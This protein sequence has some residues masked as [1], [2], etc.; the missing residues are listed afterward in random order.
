MQIDGS[1]LGDFSAR[2]V[3][4]AISN[5]YVTVSEN[6]LLLREL[7][8]RVRALEAAGGVRSGIVVTNAAIT[9]MICAIMYRSYRR[10]LRGAL[11]R[12]HGG[13]T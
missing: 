13:N 6:T 8:D 1:Q 5:T 11:S 10:N 9:A 4:Q 7:L 3:A 2:D 12:R